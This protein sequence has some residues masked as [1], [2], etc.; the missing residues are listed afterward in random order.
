[1]ATVNDLEQRLRAWLSVVL[2]VPADRLGLQDLR[3]LSGGASR[4]TWSLVADDRRLIVQTGRPGGLSGSFEGEAI[5]VRAAAAAGVPAAEVVGAT[6]DAS[7][8]G[9]GAIAMAFL[10]GEAVARPILRD[11]AYAAA[12]AV[13][14]SQTAHAAAAI[15]ALDPTAFPYL[16]VD[17][18]VAVLRHLHAGLGWA[19]PVFD[20]A[21]RWLDAHRP[22]PVEPTVV[23]GDLRLGNL[24]VDGRGLRA[25]L[26]WELAHLGDPAE[27]LMWA[28]V[29]AWRFGQASPA[30]GLGSVEELLDAYVDAGGQA[31]APERLRW[32][33]VLGTLRW[34]VICE[35]QVSQHLRGPGSVELAAIGRRVCE[36]EHDLL[37]LLGLLALAPD[38]EIASPDVPAPTLHDAP[39]AA[40]LL[41]A[42]RTW[43]T[44]DLVDGGS[45]GRTRFQARVAANVLAMVERELADAGV[46]IDAHRARLAALGL[47]GDEALCAAIDAGAFDDRLDDLADVLVPAVTAKVAVAN[48]AYLDTPRADPWS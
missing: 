43:L 39:A 24:L 35:L 2:E 12:R 46:A 44:A 34:G 48:P 19:H 30:L 22:P 23:H 36:T 33:L 6:D 27:D 25:V 37:D 16:R 20:L 38:S 13:I 26:D 21:F 41:A 15:H 47:D 18:P 4:V 8:L 14:V 28:C 17:D 7:W 31:M 1:M 9:A 10:D 11:D 40:E 29:K 32:W 45:P 3:R 42:V 5:L